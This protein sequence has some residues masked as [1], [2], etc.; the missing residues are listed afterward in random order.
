MQLRLPFFIICLFSPVSGRR[1]VSCFLL[2]NCNEPVNTVK[3]HLPYPACYLSLQL[4]RPAWII[5]IL[6]RRHLVICHIKQWTENTN[7]FFP[8]SYELWVW[9]IA[10]GLIKT[11]L[12]ALQKTGQGSTDRAAVWNVFHLVSIQTAVRDSYHGNTITWVTI[13]AFWPAFAVNIYRLWVGT[14]HVLLTQMQ[15]KV[16]GY[17]CGILQKNFVDSL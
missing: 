7:D 14:Y 15:R 12:R 10:W 17:D 16:L 2:A 1:D 5:R 9:I 6:R 4:Q 3:K 13:F 8:I 11:L